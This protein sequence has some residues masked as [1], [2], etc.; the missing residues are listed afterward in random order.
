[1]TLGVVDWGIGGLGLVCALPAGAD[2][3]YASDAGAPPYGR[4]RAGALS[5]RLLQVVCALHARGADEVV[6][7]CNAASSVLPLAGA[8]CPV[9]GVIEAGVEAALAVPGVI[10]VIGGERTIAAGRH[11]AALR[12]AGRT[13]RPRVAQPLSALVE[14]GRLSGPAVEATVDAVLAPLAGVDVLLLACTHYPALAPV[15]Q[16][17]CPGARLV[18]PVAVVAA[19]LSTEPGALSVV[20][21]GDPAQTRAAAL[22]AW[23]LDV[24]PVG[25]AWW[26]QWPMSR[27]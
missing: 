8:P 15:L 16:A 2:I 6:V 12:A 18:D 25:A 7:A 19:G 5:A 11:A 26:P 20:T 27:E 9:R 23:G 22:A 3:L 4:L 10:G 21:S 17:R 24:G 14:Q 13:V 1:V